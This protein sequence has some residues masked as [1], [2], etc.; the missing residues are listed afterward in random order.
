LR[1]DKVAAGAELSGN[2]RLAG[3]SLQAVAGSAGGKPRAAGTIGGEI[4]FSGK[5]TSPRNALSVLQGSGTLELGDAKLTALWP[6]AIAVAAEAALKTDPDKLAAVAREALVTGFAGGQLP[7]PGT[8]KVEIADGRLSIKPFAIDTAD[9]RAQGG[10]SL[11]LRALTLDSEWRLDPKPAGP[12]DKPA[13]PTVTLTYR[14]PVTS[15]GS[16]EPRIASDALERELAVR[17]MERDVE[18]LERLRKLDEARRREEAERQ[19]RQFEQ[20]PAPVPVAPAAPEPRSATP[21]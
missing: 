1:I 20:T 7:L 10:A 11:D 16:L 12:D 21:G 13:L 6:G 2:L 17:R 15:L 18:E 9:G 4:K 3:G 8:L 14:G 19:R 5:G